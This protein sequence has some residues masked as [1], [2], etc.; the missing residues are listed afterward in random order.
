MESKLKQLKVA[1]LKEI[2][3]Q[4]NVAFKERDKKEELISKILANPKAI[5]VANGDKSAPEAS[6]VSQDEDLLAPPEDFDWDEPSTT[7][8]SG[9]TTTTPAAVAGKPPTPST[10]SVRTRLI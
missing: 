6:K 3:Q 2:L 1:Q 9:S 7:V 8:K 4:S 5:M 10:S